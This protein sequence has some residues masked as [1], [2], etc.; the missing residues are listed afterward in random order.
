[1]ATLL[2]LDQMQGPDPAVLVAQNL[3]GAH[4]VDALSTL[5]MCAR[6]AVERWVCRPRLGRGAVLPWAGQDL[7]RRHRPGTLAVRGA[8]AVRPGVATANDDD[9]LA[10]GDDLVLNLFPQRG[11]VGRRQELHGLHD[12]VQLTSGDGEITWHRGADSQDDSVIPVAQRLAGQVSTDV[13][14]V[15][16]PR[17]LGLHLGQTTVKDGLLHLELG[18]A[19][20][21]QAAGLVGSLE[22]GDGMPGPGQLLGN[23]ETGR[24]GTDNRNGL[25]RQ[26]IRGLGADRPVIEGAVSPKAPD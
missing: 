7:Q 5:F 19:I 12:S 1:M 8:D 22:D 11:A 14:T 15:S 10:R 3:L 25:V 2:H 24:P 4:P 16:E 21:Q 9:V 17:A 26:A 23:G 20:A 18:D 6:D 13:D